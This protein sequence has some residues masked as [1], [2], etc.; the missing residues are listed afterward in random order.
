VRAQRIWVNPS[1]A[2]GF[3]QF[4]IIN[5]IISA[6]CVRLWMTLVEE[7]ELVKSLARWFII[8]EGLFHMEQV[9][10]RHLE[11]SFLTYL[12]HER[13]LSAFTEL[14]RTARQ[15]ILA[16]ALHRHQD[17]TAL[18]WNERIHRWPEDQLG[19]SNAMWVTGKRVAR[20]H[21]QIQA[22][23]YLFQYTR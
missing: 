6:E 5:L 14:D 1:R 20:N 11:P 9:P 21:L 3:R 18:R 4:T 19:C 15:P 16:S 17:K 10:D 12:A 23:A 22:S 13:S 8:E 2:G 7:G